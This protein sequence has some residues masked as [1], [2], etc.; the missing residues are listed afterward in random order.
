MKY[1]FI[2]MDGVLASFDN[3]QGKVATPPEDFTEDFFATREPVWELIDNIQRVF[4]EGE[5]EYH[6]LSHSPNEEST[7]GKNRFLTD[8][9]LGGEN[10]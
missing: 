3:Y 1:L 10:D 6:I 4:P 5:Y 7:K 8:I 2:D 9:L